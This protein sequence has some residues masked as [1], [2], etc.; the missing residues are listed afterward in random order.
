MKNLLRVAL[1][2]LAVIARGG[3]ASAGDASQEGARI[4]NPFR[5]AMQ[6]RSAKS[7]DEALFVEKCGMCHRQMG[8]GTVILA[9][10]LDPKIAMLEARTDLTTDLIAVAVRRGIGNM[11]RIGRGELSDAE[12]ARVAA[13]LMRK[14]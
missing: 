8:M 10:R 1:F 3:G 11:P 14:R 6:D 9:R 7:A 4:D 12:L 5:G 13:Y 2:L